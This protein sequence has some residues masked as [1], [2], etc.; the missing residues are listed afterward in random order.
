MEHGQHLTRTS[1]T[2]L[3]VNL[4]QQPSGASIR[5]MVLELSLS[6]PAL[7]MPH[8]LGLTDPWTVVQNAF[9]KKLLPQDT[10]GIYLVL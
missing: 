4:D 9:N 1:S 8:I 5:P 7:M 3:S 10:N 2:T 6:R